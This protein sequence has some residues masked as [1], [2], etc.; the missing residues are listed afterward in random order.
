M[1]RTH[2]DER[3]PQNQ[4]AGGTMMQAQ[5]T[6]THPA[7]P[8]VWFD[9]LMKTLI[10]GSGLLVFALLA[11][12]HLGASAYFFPPAPTPMHQEA[13]AGPYHVV[14]Q[15]ATSQIIAHQTTTLT[16]TLHDAQGQSVDNAALQIAPVMTTMPMESP[17]VSSTFAQG[18][19]I[20]HPVF[21]MAGIW[22]VTVTIHV[23]GQPDQNATFDLSVRWH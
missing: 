2:H 18:H 15:S 22:K 5:L 3:E 21:I 13:T 20:V 16:I 10:I 11:W 8:P 1:R 12:E 6:K 17:T 9:R 19:Y 4:A 23:T 14:L 7:E